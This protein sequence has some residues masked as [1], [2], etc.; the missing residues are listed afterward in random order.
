MRMLIYGEQ[1]LPQAQMVAPTDLC[2]DVLVVDD[3]IFR[4][5]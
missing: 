2:F 5:P 3:K 1:E 4:R